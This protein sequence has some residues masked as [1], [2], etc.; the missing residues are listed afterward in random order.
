MLKEKILIVDDEPINIS[1][2]TQVLGSGYELLVA[3]DPISA[4]DISKKE[5]PS[6]ILLDIIMPKLD[7]YE[8]VSKLKKDITTDNIPVI[9]LT[10]KS[11]PQSIVKGFKYG[12]VDYISKPF[13]KEELLARVQTHLKVHSLN[14]S[15]QKK[16]EE[17]QHYKGIMNEYVISSSTDLDGNIITVSKAFEQISKYTKDELVGKNHNVI[18]SGDMS[19]EFYEDMWK[20][21]QS[22]RTWKGEVKNKA[23]DGTLFWSNVTIVPDFNDTGKKIGYTAIRHN[24]TS[25]KKLEDIVIQDELTQLFNRRYF[26]EV[27]ESETNRAKRT[28]GGFLFMMLDIDHFKKY[29]DT[30]GHQ[31]GDTV[32]VKIGQVLNKFTK[33][34]GDYAFRLGGEEFGVISQNRSKDEALMLA[35]SIRKDVESLMIEHKFNDNKGIVTISIGLFF[36]TLNIKETTKEIYKEC[37]DMLYKAKESGRNKVVSN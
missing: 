20:T 36:R 28:S 19:V 15:L 29:N 25:Q 23:K 27:F 16:I 30:Y 12:A 31:E 3:T 35:E 6:L 5:L 2:I 18:K 4:L 24:I 33:R 1:L 26:N 7:G 22:N 37:D 11:D 8:V 34:S 21:I 32:L 17:L 10:A 13:V 9:F 14:M